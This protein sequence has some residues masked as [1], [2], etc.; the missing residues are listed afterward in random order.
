MT[1]GTD[2]GKKWPV[3]HTQINLSQYE[4]PRHSSVAAGGAVKEPLACG[5]KAHL[6]LAALRGR[7][8]TN[9][10]TFSLNWEQ[11]PGHVWQDNSPK[12]LWHVSCVAATVFKRYLPAF[13]LIYA[14]MCHSG[15][16]AVRE[17]GG[18]QSWLIF[19]YRYCGL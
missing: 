9:E 16:M 12:W 4:N 11:H 1:R 14:P 19:S 10:Q 17:K 7:V 3:T 13:M 18:K 8:A 6:R 15:I 5:G 2:E